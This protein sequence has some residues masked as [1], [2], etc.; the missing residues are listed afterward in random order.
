MGGSLILDVELSL[1]SGSSFKRPRYLRLRRSHRVILHERLVR[2]LLRDIV[3]ADQKFI[4]RCR[5]HPRWLELHHLRL[6]DS[7]LGRWLA[8]SLAFRARLGDLLLVWL[9]GLGAVHVEIFDRLH[10]S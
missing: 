7:R 6:L 5:V 3:A 8:L 1:S 2:M 4:V 9:I 10:S